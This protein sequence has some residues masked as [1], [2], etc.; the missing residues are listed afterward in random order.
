MAL[1]S[2]ITQSISDGMYKVIPRDYFI[3]KNQKTNKM[4]KESD[5]EYFINLR[6]DI[7]IGINDNLKSMMI[8]KAQQIGLSIQDKKKETRSI[9]TYQN[10]G[11]AWKQDSSV[12]TAGKINTIINTTFTDSSGYE[13]YLEA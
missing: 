7:I 12:Q 4:S 2:T 8:M 1:V 13:Y 3:T 9:Q 10:I 6:K 11:L 5:G